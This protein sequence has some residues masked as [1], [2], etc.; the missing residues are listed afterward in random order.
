M[1]HLVFTQEWVEAWAAEIRASDEYRSAAQRWTWPILF[2]LRGEAGGSGNGL[3]GEPSVFLDLQNGVCREARLGRE[4]DSARAGFVLSADAAA[5]RDVLEGRLD[6]VAG[7]MTGRLKLERGN[8]MTLAMHTG[9][10]RALVG[11]AT[12]VDA[13]FPDGP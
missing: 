5:W 12:R 8:L 7:I 6:S 1:P 13:V 9:A 3:A 10:A 11:T 2:V 4:D